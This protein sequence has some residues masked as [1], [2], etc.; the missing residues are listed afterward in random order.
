MNE[1]VYE[2]LFIIDPTLGEP[3]VEALV[4]QVQGYI[5]KEGGRVRNVEQWGKKRLAYAV[6]GRREGYYVLLVA[7]GNAGIVKEVERRMRVTE[8]VIRH[9]AVRVDEDL[10]KAET[11]RAQRQRHEAR[12]KARQAS[13]AE[14]PQVSDTQEVSE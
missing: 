9:L 11:R 1:R 7:E 10:R 6:R 14:R 13:R 5:E 2:I 3:E 8:G 12:L 4:T